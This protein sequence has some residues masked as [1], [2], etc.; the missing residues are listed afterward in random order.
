MKKEFRRIVLLNTSGKRPA[1][2][3]NLFQRNKI[4]AEKRIICGTEVYVDESERM[5]YM[6]EDFAKYI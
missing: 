4:F 3:L 1:A 6:L 5:N 2:F